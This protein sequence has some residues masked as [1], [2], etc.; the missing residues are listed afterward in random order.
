[1]NQPQKS[2]EF[3]TQ[4]KPRSL[5]YRFVDGTLQ[6]VQLVEKLLHEIPLES[7][8]NDI[9]PYNKE[10]AWTTYGTVLQSGGKVVFLVYE[11]RIIGVLMLSIGHLWWSNK[12]FLEPL[13]FW[14][15]PEYRK[16]TASIR[17]LRFLRDLADVYDLPVLF[18]V[19]SDTRL[20]SKI[21]F[22][23]RNGFI[24]RGSHLVYIPNNN[25]QQE[26]NDNY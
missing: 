23:K 11:S 13:V 20:S 26:N 7:N 18:N 8:I 22:F 4:E 16:S 10:A 9:A 24:E 17:L 6:D 3:S 19:F 1:M 5:K 15:H 21:K 14:V 25:G 2:K 12:N